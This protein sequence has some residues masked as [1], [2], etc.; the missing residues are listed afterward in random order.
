MNLLICGKWDG[1]NLWLQWDADAAALATGF[2]L[3]IRYSSKGQWE[4]WKRV[5][6]VDPIKRAWMIVAT[7]RDGGEAQARIR[8]FGAGDN[9]WVPCRECTFQKSTCDFE[10][11]SERK[12]VAFEAGHFFAS[13]VD[14]AACAYVLKDAIEIA[15]GETL[16]VTLEA[17]HSS[18]WHQLDH[19]NHFDIR[20][21]L[22]VRVR[23]LEPSVN[24]VQETGRGFTVMERVL[25][26]GPLVIAFGRKNF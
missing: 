7:Y 22:G 10:I 21:S 18:G 1:V 23:N 13:T 6:G 26:D 20:P 9:A 8:L 2:E 4:P 24:D 14:G 5:G 15:A 3:Q 16:K 25:P 19:E 11:S 12:P 17:N